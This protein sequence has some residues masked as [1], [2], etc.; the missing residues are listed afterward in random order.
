MHAPAATNIG[1]NTENETSVLYQN[2][3]NPYTQRTTI[4]FRIPQNCNNAYIYIY[5][6]RGVML[7]QIE[8]SAELGYVTIESSE[9]APGMYIYSLI[10][11]NKEVDTK[12]MILS[13]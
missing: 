4:K 3:P 10:V 7:K 2:N 8:I 1:N 13:K 6:M 12:R 9:L 5:D 11:N